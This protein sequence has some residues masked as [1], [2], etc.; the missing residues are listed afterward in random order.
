[1]MLVRINTANRSPIDGYL[2]ALAGEH[3]FCSEFK[4]HK[5]ME[6]F[7]EEEPTEY[8][9]QIIDGAVR[10]YK[11]LPDGRRQI[12]THSTCRGICL[13]SKTVR[14]IALLRTPLLKPMSA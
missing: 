10:T 5:G 13:V 9:Y 1:M 2:A 11:L 8:V 7:G 14:L 12:N 6:I 3:A 4:Y